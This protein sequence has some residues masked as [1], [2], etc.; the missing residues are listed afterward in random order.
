MQRRTF[1]TSLAGGLALA[2]CGKPETLVSVGNRTH[3]LHVGNG[4]E[5]RD[6]DPQTITALTDSFITTTLFEGIVS[7]NPD[8]M[9]PLPGV[10]ERWEIS[11]DQLVYTF[12]FRADARWSNGDSV[13][14]DDWVYSLR[15]ILAPELGSEY[16]YMLYPV[17]NAEPFNLGKLKDFA[18]VGVKALDPRTLQITLASPTPYFLS[19]LVHQ[20]WSPVQQ[21]TIEK[22]GRMTDRISKWTRPG[23]L[24]GNG[25]FVLT[26]WRVADVVA[27]KKSPTYWDRANVGLDEVRFYPVE[28]T[29]TEE[30]MLRAGQLH[31]T[32]AVP[33]AK[34]DLYRRE[35]PDRIHIDPWLETDYLRVNVTK[36]PL[37][38]KRVRR[39]LALAL[40]RRGLTDNVMRGGE[41]PA[42]SFTP[43]GMPGYRTTARIEGNADTARRLLAEAGFPGGKGFPELELHYATSE[44]G[45][46]ICQVLQ[47][48]WKKELGLPI[49]L[50]NEEFKVYLDTQRKIAYDL[51]FSI[52]V[53]DYADP[54]TFLNLM[55]T[56][57]GN[58]Q[59]H[60]GRKE[61]D[62][63]LDE[64]ARTLD[65]R[66]RFAVFDRAEN[67][68]MDELPVLPV[69]FGTHVYLSLPEVKG[70]RP[71]VAGN[72]I[73]KNVRLELP[74]EV[75]AALPA[76]DRRDTLPP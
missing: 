60:W 61:Y 63:L 46:K 15:R 20:A 67:F 71:S 38:D 5:P 37:K 59:T 28:N 76:R 40:D 43:P 57:G 14:A 66:R 52:W 64:A 12:H 53:A 70:H 4:T 32:Y 49:T 51:S 21:R 2:G 73:W 48:Q 54:A 62:D 29:S 34:I 47:E 19:L 7:L 55:V 65:P 74:R 41:V 11:D 56:D 33:R 17:K 27:V 1:L 75:T 44:T 10:A 68:L 16:S 30:H 8:T 39:A 18:A 23:N 35:H 72:I 13:T 31:V 22:F 42:F 24:V 45:M 6:L 9:E 25:P 50:R 58:N 69:F 36:G 3:T 26:E